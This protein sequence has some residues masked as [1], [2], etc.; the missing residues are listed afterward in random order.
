MGTVRA[1][2]QISVRHQDEGKIVI[3]DITGYL[4]DASEAMLSD[5]YADSDVQDAEKVLLNFETP[6][7]HHQQRF[8]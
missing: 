1:N 3:F 2:S 8:R 5:A 6:Q 4:T 7:L